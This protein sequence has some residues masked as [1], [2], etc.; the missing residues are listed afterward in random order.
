M[1]TSGVITEF[2]TPK[3]GS[4]PEGLT[5]GPNHHIW[6]TECDQGNLVR[7][8]DDGTVTEFR[9]PYLGSMPNSIIAG[10]DNTLW[11]TENRT[12]QIGRFI[13]S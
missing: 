3:E 8:N 11:F 5:V 6:F 10:P 4:G 9:L 2:A 7:L 1:T 12:S 13:A